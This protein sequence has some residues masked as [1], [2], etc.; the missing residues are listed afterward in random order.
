MQRLGRARG[1]QIVV[2]R[3]VGQWEEQARGRKYQRTALFPHRAANGGELGRFL[4]SPGR[5][6]VWEVVVGG[7]RVVAGKVLLESVSIQ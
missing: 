4:A 5:P 2:L 6:L 7:Q 3:C 1:S